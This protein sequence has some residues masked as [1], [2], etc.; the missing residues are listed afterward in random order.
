MKCYTQVN[1]SFITLEK[2]TNEQTTT[3]IVWVS[4][5]SNALLCIRSIDII[6]PPCSSIPKAVGP[7]IV[8]HTGITV[9]TGLESQSR[10]VSMLPGMVRLSGQKRWIL[11]GH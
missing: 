2:L 5:L 10:E 9:I 8:N 1:Y 7:I 3:T 11:N 6:S 4:G